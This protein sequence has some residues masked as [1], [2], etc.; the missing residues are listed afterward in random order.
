MTLLGVKEIEKDEVVKFYSA[1]VILA[2]LALIDKKM[3]ECR[4]IQ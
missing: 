3:M 1:L 2:N 4:V